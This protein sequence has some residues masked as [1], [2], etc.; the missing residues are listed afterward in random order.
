[1]FNIDCIISLSG[2]YLTF[3]IIF[4]FKLLDSIRENYDQLSNIYF[5][6]MEA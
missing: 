5:Y 2:L 6:L 1:M 3:Q 4:N